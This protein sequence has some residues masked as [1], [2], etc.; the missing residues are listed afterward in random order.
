[1]LGHM[2]GQLTLEH[3]GHSRP[4]GYIGTQSVVRTISTIDRT[5]K[6]GHYRW[7]KYTRLHSYIITTDRTIVV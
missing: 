1:M 6:L 4:D 3:S 7:E 2:T 5:I